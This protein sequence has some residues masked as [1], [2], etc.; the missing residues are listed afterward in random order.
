MRLLRTHFKTPFGCGRLQSLWDCVVGKNGSRRT[1]VR[2]R[3]LFTSGLAHKLFARPRFKISFEMGSHRWIVMGLLCVTSAGAQTNANAPRIGY[4]YPA[5]AQKGS[6]V[7]IVC[8][9][10][11]LR[12]PQTVT[13]TGDGVK[14]RVV[15]YF[16]PSRNL[17]GDQRKWLQ[18]RLKYLQETRQVEL[19]RRSTLKPVPP[20]EPKGVALPQH[21][22]LRDLESKTLRELGHIREILFA[23][24]AK[25][26]VNRQLAECVILEVTVSARAAT[27]P[28][29]LRLVTGT[30]ITNPMV[31]Q[32]GRLPEV[33]EL[34]PNSRQAVTPVRG[35]PARGASSEP[36]VLILPVVLNGQ[37]LPGDVDRFRFHEKKGSRLVIKA[38]ARTLIPYLADAVPGWFQAVVTLYDD[39]GRE[40][41]YADDERFHPDPVLCY[42]LPRTGQYDL[43]IRD[44]I[45]RGREDFVYRIEVG[46][47]P[48]VKEPSPLV[49]EPLEGLTES[50]ETASQ[51]IMEV[52]LPVL[53]RGHIDPAGD[54]DLYRFAGRAG[55]TIVMEVKSRSL[56]APLD[57][58]IRLID[59]TGRVVAWNDDHVLKEA[60]L[61]KD[62]AGLTTHHA[63]STLMTTLPRN[64]QYDVQISDAQGHGGPDYTYRL[65]IAQAQGDFALRT[66]K[67][68]LTVRTGSA[69][70]LTLHALRKEGYSGPIDIA[71]ADDA[72]GFTLQN[73]RIPAGKDQATITLKAPRRRIAEPLDLHLTGTATINGRTIIRPVVPADDVMQAFLYR[74][75]VPAKT[76]AVAMLNSRANKPAKRTKAK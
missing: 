69:V 16:R 60:H 11:F 37:I 21:P 30:G 65:R 57:S 13:V 4:L 55:D 27:G 20:K 8:S 3:A 63:D 61:Y 45:Y 53:A 68:G 24:R 56:D 67:S 74:H 34:E 42:T 52:D 44:A 59:A 58:L 73:A 54:T 31:F 43:A 15:E 32:I 17:N 48:H 70:K 49:L 18:A 5:G 47:A 22:L 76:L 29:E 71:L 46:K 26:Q 7:Q 41:A 75:L 23:P 62:L 64:G 10:Q 25:Q 19:D 38:H 51:R 12:N 14:V 28:R 72:S 9:G 33:R 1:S 66:A 36:T 6:T 2:L 40:V 50:M 39:Q 35:L